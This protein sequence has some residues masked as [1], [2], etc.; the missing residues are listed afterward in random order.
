[1]LVRRILYFVCNSIKIIVLHR[2]LND[3]DQVHL[4]L[5]NIMNEMKRF[6]MLCNLKLFILQIKGI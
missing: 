5:I 4:N 6:L 2:D 3:E 1:M